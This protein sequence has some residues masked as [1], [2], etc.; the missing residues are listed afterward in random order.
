MR[1]I[2]VLIVAVLATHTVHAATN[3]FSLLSTRPVPDAGR[4]ATVWDSPTLAAGG[5]VLGTALDYGRRPLLGTSGG[6]VTDINSFFADAHVMA[7]LGLVAPITLT[8]DLPFLAATRFINPDTAPFPPGSERLVMGDVQFALKWRLLDRERHAVG[9]AVVPF[10]TLPTGSSFTFMGSDG[11]TGG[12]T[13]VLDGRAGRRVLWALNTGAVLQ[14]HFNAFGMDFQHQFTAAGAVSVA[15]AKRVSLLAEATVKTPFTDFFQTRKTSP[16]EYRFGGQF[17]P[18]DKQRWVM[19]VM[20]GTGVPHGSGAPSVRVLASLAYRGQLKEKQAPPP[21]PQAVESFAWAPVFFGVGS[22]RI[23]KDAGE[24]LQ[25]TGDYLTRH[26]QPVEIVGH[27]D[28]TGSRRFNHTL[29]VR[30]AVAVKRYLVR[31]SVPV[32]SL[33]TAGAGER[34]PAAPNTSAKGRSQNRRVEFVR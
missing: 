26:P 31:Q 2:F 11:L 23:S 34:H 12:G 7:A 32:G 18:G 3:R 28:S 25:R 27:A 19:N 29:S 30:R 1:R 14:P 16:L 10:I 22:V 20:A 8:M 15:V 4:F 21:A 6:A 17:Y 33:R 9:V 24:V 5:F 13:V